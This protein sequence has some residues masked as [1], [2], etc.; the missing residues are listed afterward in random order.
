MLASKGFPGGIISELA[1][2]LGSNVAFSGREIVL[3]F[4]RRGFLDE[5]VWRKQ[6]HLLDTQ[7]Y[8]H[9]GSF[10]EATADESSALDS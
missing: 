7:V 10:E 8:I 6:G 4:G 9:Q 2:N 3:G 5:R 1:R